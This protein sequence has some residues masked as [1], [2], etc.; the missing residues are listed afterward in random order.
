MPGEPLT[1]HALVQ[2]GTAVLQG[3]REDGAV[4]FACSIEMF[5]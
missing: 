4:A 3:V 1:V 2:D 5:E